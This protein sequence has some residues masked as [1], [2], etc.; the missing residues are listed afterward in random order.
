[1]A[2]IDEQE[3]LKIIQ[4]RLTRIYGKVVRIQRHDAPEWFGEGWLV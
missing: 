1:L 3:I 4:E 2:D